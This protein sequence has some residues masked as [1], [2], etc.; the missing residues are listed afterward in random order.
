MWVFFLAMHLCA[1]SRKTNF[2]GKKY[3]NTFFISSMLFSLSPPLSHQNLNQQFRCL[4]NAK[5]QPSV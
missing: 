3:E 4:N 5:P 1:E 2:L